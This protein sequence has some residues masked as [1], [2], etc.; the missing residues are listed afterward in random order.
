MN[1]LE[2]Q[3]RE[4]RARMRRAAGLGA[5]VRWALYGSLLAGGWL[6]AAKLFGWPQAPL[7]AAVSLP[8]LAGIAAAARRFD[9]RHAAA[10]VDRALGLE[11]RVATALEGPGGPFGTALSTDAARALDPNRAAGVGRFRWPAEAR[12][13]IPA[14]V[15]VAILAWIPDQARTA[16]IAD[17][18]LRAAVEP[19]IDRLARV[20][21]GDAALAA[22]VKAILDDLK[23]D[24]L[25]RM[26]AGAEAAKKLAVEIRAGLAHGGGDRDALR[27]LADRLDAAGSGASTQLSRRG[28]EVPDVAPV[29]LEARVAAAKA[30]G[31]LAS[32]GARPED[33]AVAP[34]TAGAPI[35]VEVRDEIER[36]LAAKPLDPRYHEIVRR[37][38]ERWP[39][40][41]R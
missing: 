28:F 25:K 20:P 22:K 19:D 18:E 17:V 16:A 4:V 27:A 10:L 34:V 36:R 30:R 13:L 12:F 14:V 29:D 3:V 6:I 40:I 24:D 33:R 7:W 39:S 32:S 35:P 2:S 41:S 9:L 8:A 1:S 38:Y 26:A 23:S 31:D 15:M 37:Y 11:E 5:A 21:V